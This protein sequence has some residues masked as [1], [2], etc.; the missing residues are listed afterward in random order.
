MPTPN[1]TMSVSPTTLATWC[2]LASGGDHDAVQKLLWAH[3]ARLGGY[4]RRKI[5]PDWKSR[6]DPDDLLQEAYIDIFDGIA[7]F[8]YRDEDSFYYWATRIIDHRFID[9]IRRLR[10]KKRDALREVSGPAAA[11]K[12]ESFLNNYLADSATPSKHLRHAEAV[13]AMLACVA[14]LPPDYR[15]VVR[16]YCLGGESLAK[17]AADMGRSEDA[18]RRLSSR[19]VAQ[20]REAM[21]R[22]SRFFSRHD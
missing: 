7:T 3:Q 20:L 1:H 2:R 8:E 10:R 12:H 5:G 17:V 4:V 15:E 16:R 9:Q 11:S 18:V 14:A 21:R 6:I 13:S 19:A 22:A